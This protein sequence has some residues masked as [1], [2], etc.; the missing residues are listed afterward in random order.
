[1]RFRYEEGSQRS[2]QSASVF[3]PLVTKDYDQMVMFANTISWVDTRGHTYGRQLA[4]SGLFF[5]PRAVWSGK[6]EDT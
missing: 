5:V 3:D 1:D 2:V 4:G 6:P